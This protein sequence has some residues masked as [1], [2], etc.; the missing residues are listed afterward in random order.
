MTCDPDGTGR[1]KLQNS[2]KLVLRISN[3]VT[4]YM[5]S[6]RLSSNEPKTMACSRSVGDVNAILQVN[7]S[8]LPGVT[9]LCAPF[10]PIHIRGVDKWSTHLRTHLGCAVHHLAYTVHKFN[11]VFG[12]PQNG[13]GVLSK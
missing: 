5:D 11:F 2:E 3:T 6:F 12:P 13:I 7:M 1:A 4:N 9:F 10:T 8:N